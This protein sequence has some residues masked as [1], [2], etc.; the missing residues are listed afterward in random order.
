MLGKGGTGG[1]LFLLA[2]HGLARSAAG[3][4]IRP[5]A[6]TTHGKTHAVATSSQAS[7]VLQ[8]LQGHALLPAQITFDRE[9][10]GCTSK[11]LDVSVLEILDSD[12]GVDS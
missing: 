4:G 9:G 5:G 8:A 11:F 10:F 12:V 3:S 2:S 7:N 1:G 6:L